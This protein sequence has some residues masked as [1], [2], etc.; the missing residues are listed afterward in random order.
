MYA[1]V[2]Y[3]PYIYYLYTHRKCMNQFIHFISELCIIIVVKGIWM[4]QQCGNSA[5][6]IRS[7]NIH[8]SMLCSSASYSPSFLCHTVLFCLY[9]SF[10]SAVVIPIFCSRIR[11]SFIQFRET[12]TTQLNMISITT[13]KLA[14]QTDIYSTKYKIENYVFECLASNLEIV[15]ISNSEGKRKVCSHSCGE[16]CNNEY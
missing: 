5:L 12:M 16:G 1:V 14:G 7:V 9:F 4:A 10:I 13:G 8:R 2:I 11:K 15:F 3:I 6:V